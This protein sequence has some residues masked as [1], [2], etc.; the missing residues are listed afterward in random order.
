MRMQS[1]LAAAAATMIAVTL[2]AG[3]HI[4]RPAAADT[5]LIAQSAAALDAEQLARVQGRLN[6]LG[7]QAGSVDG[8]MGPQTLQ[9]IMRFQASLGDRPTGQ[10]SAQQLDA[11]FTPPR[12]ASTTPFTGD[13][14]ASV[15]A[16]LPAY[17]ITRLQTVLNSIGYTVGLEDGVIG[18]RMR[19]AVTRYQRDSG[20]NP[21]GFLTPETLAAIEQEG[22][23]FLMA[24][25]RP[26]TTQR[27]SRPSFDCG[28]A[29]TSTERAIC[30]NA[31]LGDLDR[32][33]A[34][35]YRAALAANPWQEQTTRQAQRNW[36]RQRNQCGGDAGCLERAMLQRVG[37]LQAAAGVGRAPSPELAPGGSFAQTAP[38]ADGGQTIAGS[39]F[40]PEAPS[41]STPSF[42]Q[43]TGTS[44][45]GPVEGAWF[46]GEPLEPIVEDGRFVY[47]PRGRCR[48]PHSP[49][50]P[51][52]NDQM[53]AFA[54]WLHL[55]LVNPATIDDMDGDELSAAFY[56]LPRAQM[57]ALAR[58]FQ[59]EG[60]LEDMRLDRNDLVNAWIEYNAS[61][62]RVFGLFNGVGTNP[63]ALRRAQERMRE[64]YGA[65]L[66]SGPVFPLAIREYCWAH[67]G[68]YDFDRQ[69]MVLQ[70]D[71]GCTFSPL[72][73][74]MPNGLSTVLPMPAADAE[75]LLTAYD[76][77]RVL[78]SFDVDIAG[79]TQ[80]RFNPANRSFDYS[81]VSGVRL[82][83][84]N[85]RSRLLYTF[86][87]Q[88]GVLP[89]TE[90]SSPAADQPSFSD[91]GQTS[92]D[93]VP[94]AQTDTGPAVALTEA[95][96]RTFFD[97]ETE[98]PVPFIDGRIPFG[99][100]CTAE[101]CEAGNRALGTLIFEQLLETSPDQVTVYFDDSRAAIGTSDALVQYA[102]A[103]DRRRILEAEFGSPLPTEVDEVLSLGREA[104]R[105][106]AIWIARVAPNQ[107]SLLRLRDATLAFLQDSYGSRPS[108]GALPLRGYCPLTLGQV[109][110]DFEAERFNFSPIDR[111]CGQVTV[112]IRLG[113]GWQNW[114]ETNL[115]DGVDLY[116]PAG[117]SEAEVLF[118]QI[119]AAGENLL[120][121]LDI[122]AG[123]L[124]SPRFEGNSQMPVTLAAQP[125]LYLTS[126]L[127][128]PI[129]I[130]DLDLDVGADAPT[131]QSAVASPSTQTVDAAGLPTIGGDL[132]DPAVWADLAEETFSRPANTADYFAADTPI[133]TMRMNAP[134][135]SPSSYREDARAGS[136]DSYRL[137]WRPLTDGAPVAHSLG[138]PAEYMLS[139]A[140]RPYALAF[141]ALSRTTSWT[142]ISVACALKRSPIF[143]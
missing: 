81:V 121:G 47:A 132:S 29:R 96:G 112:D 140:G 87:S 44:R 13:A 43:Q 28:A 119:Q 101:A 83:P 129:A 115:L 45:A 19:D 57:E 62:Q 63:F 126:D 113:G 50:P 48:T 122:D 11:L 136:S 107:F 118:E 86:P 46:M 76:E 72:E 20:L 97:G 95:S 61:S 116:L 117:V 82:H 139:A 123:A 89:S 114:A 15:E 105:D 142:S 22:L 137:F 124:R 109:P 16:E 77:R 102:D 40:E 69:G 88:G 56:F 18:P 79:A 1:F 100:R 92:N 55:A 12:A 111:S 91:T 66:D 2:P 38:Q 14:Q 80:A 49:R 103:A 108:I 143:M 127:S 131:D 84:I 134:V 42:S 26:Q 4:V 110:Y 52:C 23:A 93:D 85:D 36:L 133:A 74:N 10:L 27:Q 37:V 54:S 78:I 17:V 59:T 104:L 125:A 120:L 9:A 71:R 75:A 67:L 68:P 32:M 6:E 25:S 65:V 8:A 24:P 70:S 94:S 35:A 31:A 3:S 21:S 58:E 34:D 53:G 41:E 5:F 39:L 141:P 138:L 51:L 106:S 60:L 99:V 90:V 30:G 135:G 128:T 33:L 73:A 98:Q 7:F 64:V 130:F